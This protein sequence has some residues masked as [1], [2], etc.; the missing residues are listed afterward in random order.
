MVAASL[1]WKNS[2]ADEPDLPPLTREL[3]KNAGKLGLVKRFD[4]W[5]HYVQP[6]LDGAEKL[7]LARPEIVFRVYLA[8]DLEFLIEDFVE[9]ICEV[10]VMKSSSIRHNPGAMWRFLALEYEGLV[11]PLLRIISETL[12]K[13]WYDRL[14]HSILANRS[15]SSASKSRY[16]HAR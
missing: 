12:L 6:L 2:Q 10:Q 11:D 3:L 7:A 16:L 9:F 4:P 5:P 13:D 1:F 8:A 15:T 14:N